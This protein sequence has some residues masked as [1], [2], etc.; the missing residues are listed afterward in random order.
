MRITQAPEDFEMCVGGWF[1]I[2]FGEGCVV[3]NG[4]G[5]CDVEEMGGHK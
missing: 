4:F 5:G 2:E 1:V 3:L